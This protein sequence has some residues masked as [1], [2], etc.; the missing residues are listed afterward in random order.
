[1]VPGWLLLVTN[2][3]VPGPAHF[4]DA[5]AREFGLIL[6]YTEKLLEELTGAERVYTAALGESSPHFHAHLVP[7]YEVMPKDAV[8]WSVFDLERVRDFSLRFTGAF[9]RAPFV[10][11]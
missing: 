2:R 3:H 1:V 10:D 4:D 11:H 6:R 8:G 5:E 9:E 7:R